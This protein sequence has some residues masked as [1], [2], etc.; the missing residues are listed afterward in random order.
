[1]RRILETNKTATSE[2][3]KRARLETAAPERNARLGGRSQGSAAPLRTDPP[4]QGV[5]HRVVCVQRGAEL[6]ASLR[7]HAVAR[8]ERQAKTRLIADWIS[9][10]LAVRRPANRGIECPFCGVE[11]GAG[12]ARTRAAR[13]RLR[14]VEMSLR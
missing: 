10:R 11:R 6:L 7:R 2:E 4:L 12:D 9:L 8:A 1:M 14:K 13:R 5:R 3:T